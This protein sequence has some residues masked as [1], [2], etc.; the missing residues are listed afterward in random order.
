MTTYANPINFGETIPEI[1]YNGFDIAWRHNRGTGIV[2]AILDSGIRPH[3]DLDSQVLDGQNFTTDN[4]GVS[5][6]Y[7]EGNTRYLGTAIA[8]LYCGKRT[9]G[10]DGVSGGG[11]GTIDYMGTA[12]DS[13]IIVGKTTLN[14]GT[15]P[16]ANVI[17]GINWAKDWVGPQGETVDIILL[18]YRSTT[19]DLTLKTAIDEATAAGIIVCAPDGGS[20]DSIETTYYPDSYSNVISIGG[21]YTN[22]NKFTRGHSTL[23][24]AVHGTQYGIKYIN[25]TFPAE[26]SDTDSVLYPE[27]CLAIGIGGIALILQAYK[28]ASNPITGYAQFLTELAKYCSPVKTS[29]ESLFGLGYLDFNKKPLPNSPYTDPPVPNTTPAVVTVDSVAHDKV[30]LSWTYAPAQ[31]DDVYYQIKRDTVVIGEVVGAQTF[32]DYNVN[33]STAYNY[34]VSVYNDSGFVSESDIVPATTLA[35]VI[36]NT[37]APVVTL[38][39]VTHESVALSW[40]YTAG[41]NDDVYYVITRDNLTV[42]GQDKDIKSFTDYTV[43]PETAYA[44][45]V[46]VYN[47]LGLVVESDVINVTTEKLPYV[48]PIVEFYE[49]PFYTYVDNATGEHITQLGQIKADY[50]KTLVLKLSPTADPTN[51][52]IVTLMTVAKDFLVQNTGYTLNELDTMPRAIAVFNMLV[53]DLYFERTTT[54]EARENKVYKA[55]LQSIQ[56]VVV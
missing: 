17:A 6:D 40:D 38:G 28:E 56:Q 18:T 50:V 42:I 49:V 54:N 34:T 41:Q 23:N 20:L 39:T 46:G 3:W 55:M 44:Y 8:S 37:T 10:A 11:A 24:F 1:K 36:P 35:Y 26:W 32:T 9:M 33:V 12:P 43:A 15:Q 21:M 13:K 53:T 16:V 25:E 22:G 29:L 31:S 19:E 2:T 45:T 7:T 47:E 30:T 27:R 5:T 51:E 4:G 52:H 48:E 14:D